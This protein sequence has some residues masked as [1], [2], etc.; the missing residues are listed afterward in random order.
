MLRWMMLSL[1]VAV[2]MV[3][4]AAGAL[5]LGSTVASLLVGGA[6]WQGEGWNLWVPGLLPLFL[7]G[8]A[9]LVLLGPSPTGE[10]RESRGRER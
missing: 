6:F 3:A 4:W 10:S 2:G 5:N 9:G 7:L 1:L 8:L